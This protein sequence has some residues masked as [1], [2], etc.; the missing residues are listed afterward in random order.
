MFEIKVEGVEAL[1]A[2][3]EKYQKQIAD[4]HPA[5][6]LEL[7]AWQREDMKRKNPNTETATVSNE[8]TATTYVWPR[9]RTPSKRKRRYQAPKKFQPLRRG[10]VVRSNRPILR[11]ELLEQLWQRMVRLTAEATKWP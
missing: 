9:S 8:T 11:A 10:P 1:V 5:V 2:K 4:L 7:E 3:L 6:P